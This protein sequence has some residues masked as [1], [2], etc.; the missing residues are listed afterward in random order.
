[1][2]QW[3]KKHRCV[4]SGAGSFTD[5]EIAS[6]SVLRRTLRGKFKQKI[7]DRDGNRCLLCS[8]TED[9]TLQHVWPHSVG[10]ETS[11]GN[12]VTLC[13]P[14]NQQLGAEFHPGL[15]DLAGIQATVDGPFVVSSDLSERAFIRA[16][17]L[18]RNIMYTRC[19][20]F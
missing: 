14:C 5:V 19:D 16:R 1:M 15:F 18:T 12:L 8:D 4:I 11:S 10:G 17:Y 3:L 20:T 7:L 2:P 6:P 13:A 9:L